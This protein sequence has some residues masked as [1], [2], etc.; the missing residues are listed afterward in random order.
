V[1]PRRHLRE[2]H[3]HGQ[4]L[5]RR[6]LG[7]PSAV[8]PIARHSLRAWVGRLHEALFKVDDARTVAA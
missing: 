5:P 1:P 3:W 4:A 6:H 8:G 7:R 2:M